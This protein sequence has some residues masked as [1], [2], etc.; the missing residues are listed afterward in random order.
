MGGG[1]GGA[2]TKQYH[3]HTHTHFTHKFLINFVSEMEDYK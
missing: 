1:G 3:T 2:K